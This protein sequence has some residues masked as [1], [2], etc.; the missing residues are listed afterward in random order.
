MTSARTRCAFLCANTTLTGFASPGAALYQTV[1]E[2]VENAL[3]AGARTVFVRV[4][5]TDA[6]VAVAAVAK[7]SG[8]RAPPP[9]PEP[10]VCGWR[11]TIE[12]DG[13]GIPASALPALLG[14]VFG[15]SKAP[16]ALSAS[17]A[18]APLGVASSLGR[19]G[20]GLKVSQNGLGGGG[21]G[22]W[23]WGV[24]GGL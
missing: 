4:E 14:S 3:D 18:A 24:G 1:R 6:P 20:V 2:L 16:A 10:T 8:A 22:G 13:E 21:W 7:R 12:D 17:P 11:V 15:S 19:Y 9:P 5:P 23:G